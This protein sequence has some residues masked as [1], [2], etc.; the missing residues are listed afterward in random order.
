[1]TYKSHISPQK[2]TLQALVSD[3]FQFTGRSAVLNDVFISNQC[4]KEFQAELVC[5]HTQFDRSGGTG[6][7]L[8]VLE[9]LID[10]FQKY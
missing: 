3:V 5:I 9:G 1:M 2:S 6:R 10:L 8:E 4:S 7:F